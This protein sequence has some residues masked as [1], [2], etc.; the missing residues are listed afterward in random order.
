MERALST[1]GAAEW[2]ALMIE[3]GV[4]AGRVLSVPEILAQP[5]L[6]DRNFVTAFQH[7]DGAQNIARGGFQ[8][9]DDPIRPESPAP[10]LSQDTDRWL[11]E[12]GHESNEIAELR[13][14]GVI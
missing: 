1:R 12:L 11:R 9:P 3:A 6:R 13:S 5:H 2:E 10:K 8:F 7:P 14:K 4:P